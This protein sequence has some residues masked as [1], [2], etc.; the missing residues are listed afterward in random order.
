MCIYTQ[1]NT[2]GHVYSL[3]KNVFDIECI[4]DAIFSVQLWYFP[5]VIT[6][7]QWS[8]LPEDENFSY[9]ERKSMQ[10]KINQKDKEDWRPD[11][12]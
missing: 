11:Y 4:L 5:K 7:F 1:L 12:R 6:I 2:P 8:L 9:F 10:Y 3:S